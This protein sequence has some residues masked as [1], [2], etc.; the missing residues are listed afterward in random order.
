MP[1]GG[2]FKLT[3]PRLRFQILSLAQ[4]ESLIIGCAPSSTEVK[5]TTH[6][7]KIEGSNRVTGRQKESLIIGCDPG[8]TEA[9][10]STHNP[11]IVG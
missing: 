4:G 6:N 2:T 8:S 7:P 3:I 11:N 1:L 10:Q 9:E 5:H